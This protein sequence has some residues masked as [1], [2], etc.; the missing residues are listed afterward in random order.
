MENTAVRA[1]KPH[2]LIGDVARLMGLSRDTLRYYEK[3]GILSSEKGENGYRYYT[4]QDIDRL[5][6]ILYQRKMNLSLDRME[7]LCSE[8][9]DPGSLDSFLNILQKQIDQEE[10]AIRAHRQT[11]ARLNMTLS[12]CRD[13]R[14]N[15]A[16][17]CLQELPPTCVIVP[18]ATR[19]E[20]S[21]LWFQYA[22]EYSGLDM[23]Y[24]VDEY[25]WQQQDG[26]TTAEYRNTQLVLPVEQKEYVDYDFHAQAE[27][28]F[29]P[30]SLA[31]SSFHVLD[32]PVPG[33][34]Q[35]DPMLEWARKQDLM[36]SHQLYAVTVLQG[37]EKDSSL[38]YVRLYIPVF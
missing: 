20:A 5:M 30:A 26:V 21:R 22:R 1:S 16:R 32:D 14:D 13:F 27:G 8:T 37:L 33:P 15:T 28:G 2:Y 12:D 25:T 18:R 17:V 31:V 38:R 7:T 6:G 29:S 36:T 24:L 34:A 3:R 11:I 10:Q 9:G 35:I 4:D 19:Q 23:M